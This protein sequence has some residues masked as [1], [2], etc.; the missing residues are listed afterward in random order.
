MLVVVN[1]GQVGLGVRARPVLPV[2]DA[3]G[4]E[5]HECFVNV[6]V[7]HFLL[8][9]LM[10]SGRGVSS[11]PLFLRQGLDLWG[12]SVYYVDAGFDVAGAEQQRRSELVERLL[13]LPLQDQRLTQQVVIGVVARFQAQGRLTR[14]GPARSRL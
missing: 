2:R 12:M 10:F 5:A 11:C 14:F 4:R 7:R 9:W 13:H 1:A 3:L 6:R 8:R